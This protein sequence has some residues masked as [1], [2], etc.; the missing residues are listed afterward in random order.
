MSSVAFVASMPIV[1]GVEVELA[2]SSFTILADTNWVQ[3][4]VGL[5]VSG[6]ARLVRY[7]LRD[8][9]QAPRERARL[10]ELCQTD[11]NNKNH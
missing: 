8:R 4:T 6:S 2:G 11:I 7:V 1:T 3:A 5:P 9:L 10:H